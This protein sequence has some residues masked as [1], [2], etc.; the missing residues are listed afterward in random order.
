MALVI[1]CISLVRKL[2]ALPAFVDEN[3]H[4]GIVMTGNHRFGHSTLKHLQQPVQSGN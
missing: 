1:V 2:C 4:G 3:I